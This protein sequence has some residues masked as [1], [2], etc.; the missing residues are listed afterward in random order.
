[1]DCQANRDLCYITDEKFDFDVS[2]SPASAKGDEEEDE[3]FVGPLSHKERCI[4]VNVASHLEGSDGVRVS[5]SPLTG[6]LSEA[7]CQEAHKLADQL[8]SQ[9]EGPTEATNTN[10]REEFLQ[11]AEAKLGMLVRGSSTLSP[12]KR[13][14]FLVQDSPMKELPPAVQRRL[15]RGSSTKSPLTTRTSSTPSIRPTHSVSSN[16]TASTNTTASTRTSTRLST[17]SPVVMVKAQPKTGLRG[18]AA[19]G[20]VLPSKPAGPTASATK[21]RVDKSRLQP[22]SK[23]GDKMPVVGSW[24]RSP[25]SHPSSRAGSCEDLLS[26]SASVASDISD[27][28]L[29]SSLLGKRTMAPPSKSFKRNLS[30]VKVPPLQNRRITDR[31]NTSS[32]SSSVSSFN[33]SMSLSPAKGKLNS[34]LNRSISGSAVPAPSSVGKAANPT[35]TRSS[36]YGTVAPAPTN[37]GRR[38]LSTQVRRQSEVEPSKATKSTP[39]KRA[40]AT[41]LQMTPSKRVLER[42]ASVPSA[43]SARLQSGQKTKSKPEAMVL[44]TPSGGFRGVP[45]K[46]DVSKMKPKRPMSTSSVDSLPQKPS[47]G[48]LTPSAGS[49]RSLQMKARRPSTLPTPVKRRGSVIPTATPT[50]LARPSRSSTVSSS[51]PAPS[52]SV[53]KREKSC[54]PTPANTQVEEVE[55]FVVPEV[56]PFHLEEAEQQQQPSVPTPPSPP[57]SDQSES[58][59][60]EPEPTQ[61]E[62]R[63]GRDLIQLETAEESSSKTQEVLLLDLPAPILQ[64]QEKLLIDLTNT[65]DLIRT[66]SKS[67]SNSQ[68]IDLTSP[69]IKWSPEDKRENNAPLI[70]LSF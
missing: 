60:P 62:P 32:S 24:K 20:I 34:S 46:D 23:V 31:K 17:S 25:S 57:L 45:Q 15:L 50:N 39:L 28:S 33:S 7:M 66:S 59:E 6:E 16:R 51:G 4:S 43:A 1:M 56:Q 3:V 55:V 36:V 30:A 21:T 38:S 67:S 26:D 9:N 11:D 27:S 42:A 61:S 13:Q 64:P 52:P 44:P 29:N 69:L 47:A 49:G 65:P 19:L 53:I 58:P 35:S 10:S 54:S 18:K 70:N 2:L 68:L 14:T 12:I 8:K 41:P 5:W 22:P 37:A 48:P 63:P 40:E